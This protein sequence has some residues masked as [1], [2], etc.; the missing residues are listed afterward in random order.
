MLLHINGKFTMKKTQKSLLSLSF[1]VAG[2]YIYLNRYDITEFVQQ[3]LHMVYIYLN[4]YDITE[5]VQQHLHMVY[6]YLNRYDITEF[7]QQHLHVSVADMLLHINGKFTMKKTQ[8]S[9]LSL[10]FV[11]AAKF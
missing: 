5:F 11:V 6:V 10:S 2:V 7:V 1:V 8:K 9:L 4:R 3:H